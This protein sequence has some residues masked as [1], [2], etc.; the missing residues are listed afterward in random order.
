MPTVGC[1]SQPFPAQWEE[2][3]PVPMTCFPPGPGSPTSSFP[4][5]VTNGFFFQT[6]LKAEV[7]LIYPDGTIKSKVSFHPCKLVLLCH[8]GGKTSNCSLLCLTDFSGPS[9]PQQFFCGM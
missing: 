3:A 4:L 1:L 2:A 8:S 7:K 6:R 9:G 5:E